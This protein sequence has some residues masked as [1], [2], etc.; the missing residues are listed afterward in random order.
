MVLLHWWRRFRGF[1]SE[2]FSGDTAAHD[3][4]VLVEEVPRNVCRNSETLDDYACSM[5]SL[6][7]TP[8]YLAVTVRCWSCLRFTGL[9][10]LFRIQFAL[11]RQWIHVGRQFMRP[12]V[13]LVCVWI[14]QTQSRAGSTVGLSCSQLQLRSPPW[15]RSQSLW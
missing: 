5:N 3:L 2:H 1:S 14:W 4:H 11:V 7:T 13:A 15:C 10:I 8:L 12:S 6:A 9:W